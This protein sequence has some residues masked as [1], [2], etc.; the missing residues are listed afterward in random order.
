MS[1]D[2]FS[3]PS[4]KQIIY[5]A[6]QD[7]NDA[8]CIDDLAAMD[9]T[10]TALREQIAI[11]KA[12][13]KLLRSNLA[14]LNATMSTTELRA[15]VHALQSSKAE[16]LARLGPLMKGVVK[17][18]TREEKAEVDVAWKMWK[19]KALVRKKIAME[20]WGMV[21]EVLPEG[22]QNGELWVSA[23]VVGHS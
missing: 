6:L 3:I 14:S 12:N 7:P 2:V 16:L 8:L 10:I 18:V 23:L 15:Q 9:H 21:T 22:K 5:H 17:P 1:S 13:E 4:G 11:L 20:L 19:Q